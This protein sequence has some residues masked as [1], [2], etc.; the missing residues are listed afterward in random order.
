MNASPIQRA[1]TH[2]IDSS[3]L[4]Q[5]GLSTLVNRALELSKGASPNQYPG[6]RIAALFC[7]PSL[8]TRSSMEFAASA[9]GA[10]LVTLNSGQGLWQIEH[11][12]GVVMNED[13]PEHIAEVAGVLSEMAHVLALRTFA[14]LQDMSMDLGD[15][16]L[17]SFIEHSSKPVINLESALW[18][19]LQGIADTATWTNHL[20]NPKGKRITLTWAP[21]PKALPTAVANQVLLSAALQGMDIILAHP[22]PFDLPPHV[23]ERCSSIAGS[24]GGSLRV[25]H[26]WK[27]AYKG[28]QVVV[29]KSWSGVQGYGNRFFETQI[30]Q[31]YQEWMVTPDKMALTDNAGFMHCLPV[32]RNVVVSDAVIDG[33]MSWTKYTA[34]MRMW[35]AM[36][37]L[38]E[39]LEQM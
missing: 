19:P 24:Q 39:M 6:S 18:H 28:A 1:S 15:R 35:T 16:I 33:P 20:G 27:D 21:H 4:G 22:K 13:K 12:N 32:R 23:M 14:G 2:F 3:E 17:S 31:N 25:T 36:A 8:R 9:V 10:K 34:G 5:K 26:D 11:R 38:E 30:R 37:L 7:N 29:A